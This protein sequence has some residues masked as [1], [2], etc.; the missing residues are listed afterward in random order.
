M[1]LIGKYKSGRR[2]IFFA[3]E[4]VNGYLDVK[5]VDAKDKRGFSITTENKDSQSPKTYLS[6]VPGK[7]WASFLERYRIARPTGKSEHD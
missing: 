2:D 4:I 3:Y 6:Y 1:S 5:F 7:S